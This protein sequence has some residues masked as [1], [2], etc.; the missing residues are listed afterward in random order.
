M[1]AP[2]IYQWTGHAMQ[3]LGRFARI[4]AEAFKAGEHYRMEAIE[5]RSWVSHNHQFAWLY[6]AWLNLPERAAMEPWAQSS[7]HLR[8]FAL[9]KTG[10][11][12]TQT[13]ICVTKAEAV[14]W[15]ANMRPEDEFSIVISQGNTV[16]RFT[17]KSQSLK[18][19]GAKDFQASKSAILEYIARLIGVDPAE[20]AAQESAQ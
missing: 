3:P 14:R 4:A 6:D 5:A 17:A 11:C 20:L 18:A 10:F 7:E 15:A 12:N 9:I 8:K 13:W 2:F 1:P 19:M 16:L